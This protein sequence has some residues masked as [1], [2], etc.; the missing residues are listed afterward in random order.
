[1]MLALLSSLS[2]AT[3]L[4]IG[5][6]EALV[7]SGLDSPTAMEFAPDGRLFVCEKAGTI[8]IIKDGTLLPTP[9][10]T[11]AAD[12]DSERGL[13][14]IAFDPDFAN[15]QFVYVYYTA[16]EPGIHNRIS[17]LQA[18]GDVAASEE[19]LFE[20]PS[21]Q[22]AIWHMGGALHFGPDGKLYAAV[23]IYDDSAASQSLTSVLGKMLR[24]NS[25]GTIPSDNPFLKSTTGV[26]QAIWAIG[27]RNAFTSSFQPGTGRFFINDVGGGAWEEIDEGRAG[28]NY[29]WPDSEGATA[30]PSFITPVFAY[31]H[32]SSQPIHGDCIA[33]GAFYNPR[34][35]QFPASFVGKYFFADYGTGWIK[36][37]DPTTR[38]VS[39]FASGVS[40]PVDV[41]V[42]ADGELF[43][44]SR[45][46]SSIYKILSNSAPQITAQPQ[47]Q[48]A[49][50]GEN[51]TF[52]V[53][54]SGVSLSYQWQRNGVDIPKATKP[55]LT[56]AN[57]T[58]GDSG[59]IFSVRVNNSFGTVLS[60]NATLTVTTDRPP[61][62]AIISPAAKQHYIAGDTIFYAGSASDTKDGILDGN[63]F[64]WWVDFHHDTHIH[65]FIA[66]YTGAT[67]GTFTVPLEAHAEGKTWF[68]INLAVRDSVGFVTT[69]S[70]DIFPRTSTLKLVTEPRGLQLTL[71]AEPHTAP[72]SVSGVVN[73]R[74]AVGALPVQTISDVDYE[75]LAWSDKG[76]PTHDIVWPGQD[77]VLKA[78]YR[79]DAT[80][81]LSDLTPIGAPINGWGPFEKDMSNGENASGDGH[82]L[83]LNGV[84]YAKG[85]GVHAYSEL[86][87]NLGGKFSKFVS[88]V[89]VDD[90]AGTQ[91]SVIFQVWSDGAKLFDSGDV[92]G[93]SP[94][95]T[96][97]ADVTGKQE[98]ELAVADI[99]DGLTNDHADW[100][101]ARLLAAAG[102][103][104]VTPKPSATPTPAPA[105]NNAAT[106]VSW[107]IPSAVQTSQSFEVSI[108]LQNSGDTTWSAAN[109]QLA[110]IH[111]KNNKTWKISR[112]PLNKDTPPGGIAT[113]MFQITA[114]SA[115]G[116]YDFQWSMIKGV[117]NFFDAATPLGQIQVSNP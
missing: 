112:A 38:A 109:Y 66:Q 94:T 29:G 25:D 33:G 20:L 16:S 108:S 90:E 59:S 52:S 50:K 56:L 70:R 34:T 6:T 72:A 1:M 116:V 114:P 83:T 91:G 79:R 64:T 75:F 30:N 54:A 32:D 58:L 65:P 26:C 69:K 11:L 51:A 31:S 106:F 105:K 36:I 3:T 18:S 68:R 53:S 10:A 110:S 13:L 96:V 46:T 99:G 57:L 87:Y 2:R 5:F 14:G 40:N 95:Q 89:G 86:H 12:N 35:A 62:V 98:L 21:V 117:A 23:G 27:L 78:T 73:S 19:V 17:R 85:L 47:N 15:N 28:G 102:D 93:G 8:R 44:L 92:I 88:D 39:D 107:T 22:N 43:Y 103:K 80:T 45:G 48:L 4:P 101:G 82:P 61:N 7:A 113:F 67:S 77:S 71:E 49:S 9:F 63:A 104:P 100:A 42:S 41:K 111:P 55:D 37:L 97:V 76:A 115:A 24:I 81:F 60:Q 84:T 74:L